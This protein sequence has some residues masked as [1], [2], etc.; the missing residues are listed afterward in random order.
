[1]NSEISIIEYKCDRGH[2]L[3]GIQRRRC[4]QSGVWDGPTDTHSEPICELVTCAAP[5]EPTVQA[6]DTSNLRNTSLK[7]ETVCLKRCS[8]EFGSQVQFRCT[9]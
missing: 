2:R 8:T 5:P 7:G 1:M 9:I 3:L 4:T 6:T